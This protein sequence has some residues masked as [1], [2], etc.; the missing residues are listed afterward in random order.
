MNSDFVVNILFIRTLNWSGQDHPL[1][2]TS[3]LQHDWYRSREDSHPTV[4]RSR[5]T[6][7]LLRPLPIMYARAEISEVP[8]AV[9]P[10]GSG[11]GS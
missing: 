9:V 10:G 7:N 3:R 11:R 8:R 6:A 2:T 1:L 5:E 4:I